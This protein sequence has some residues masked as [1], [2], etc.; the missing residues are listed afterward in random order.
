M[1]ED[2]DNWMARLAAE[3][4]DVPLAGLEGEIA[5]AIAGRRAQLG[6]ARA[7]RRV[8]AVAVGIGI[9]MGVTAGS[10]VA[11]STLLKAEPYASLAAV[12]PLAPSILLEGGR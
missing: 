1:S 5:H 4:I 3:P 9:A 8:R 11:M 6:T 7:L 12:S 10:A 2:L